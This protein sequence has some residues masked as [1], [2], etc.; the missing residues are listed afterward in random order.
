V[1]EFFK[2]MRWVGTRPENTNNRT[3]VI[4]ALARN[5]AGIWLGMARNGVK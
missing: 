2:V 4:W 5:K 1:S 3:E